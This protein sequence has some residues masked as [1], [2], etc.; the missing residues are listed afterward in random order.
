MKQE[1]IPDPFNF[2]QRESLAAWFAAYQRR[3]R[4]LDNLD[5][6]SDASH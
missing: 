6:F 1:K 5:G 2:P 3:L 4:G